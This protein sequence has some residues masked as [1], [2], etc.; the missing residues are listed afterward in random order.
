MALQANNINNNVASA[1][2]LTFWSEQETK[3]KKTRQERWQELFRVAMT[4]DFV[5]LRKGHNTERK[6]NCKNERNFWNH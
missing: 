2:L 4:V 3:Q 5:D 6:I 1:G